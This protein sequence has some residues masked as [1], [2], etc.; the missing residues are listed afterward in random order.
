[1]GRKGQGQDQVAG[2]ETRLAVQKEGGT[3]GG[4]TD[5][6]EGKGDQVK[7]EP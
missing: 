7:T 3:A 1:M 5:G 4:W 6:P 2:L